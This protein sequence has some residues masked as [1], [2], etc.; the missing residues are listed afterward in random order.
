[1]KFDAANARLITDGTLDSTEAGLV[2]E[3]DIMYTM[4]A[5]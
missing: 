3:F 1:M 2:Y 5:T 4:S